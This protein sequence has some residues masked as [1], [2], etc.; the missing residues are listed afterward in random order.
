MKRWAGTSGGNSI[1]IEYEDEDPGIRREFDQ[2]QEKY[3]A[4]HDHDHSAE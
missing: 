1:Q 3:T 2:E 4:H